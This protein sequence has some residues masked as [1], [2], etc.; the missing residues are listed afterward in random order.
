R[1]AD[2]VLVV[3]LYPAHEGRPGAL[4]RVPAGSPAPLAAGEI[5]REQILAQLSEADGRARRRGPLALRQHERESADHLV[6]LAA[7]RAQRGS[8]GALIG[9][10]TV[11]LPAV[12][13]DGVAP[14]DRLG[15]VRRARGARL[16]KRAGN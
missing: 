9:R 5:P 12:R 8:R 1:Q 13:D 2:D 14:D 3:P 7:Q 16:A 11:D 6:R 10:L 4:D 15:P